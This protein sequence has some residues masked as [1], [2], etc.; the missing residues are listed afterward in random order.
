MRRRLRS[1]LAIGAMAVAALSC[2]SSSIAS[3]AS[4]PSENTAILRA[5]PGNPYP[6]GWA[7]RTVRVSTVDAK[8]AF[9]YITA[10]RGHQNQVQPDVASMYHTTR[11]G[12]V[13]HQDGNGGGCRMPKPIERDLHLAC[14]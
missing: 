8:W 1:M 10:N 9:V 2:A 4:K 11:H 5:A 6:R 14:Y 12:W 13:V 3:R 7:H